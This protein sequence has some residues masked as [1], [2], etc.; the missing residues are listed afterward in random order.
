MSK[1]EKSISTVFFVL[2]LRDLFGGIELSFKKQSKEIQGIFKV[3]RVVLI[4]TWGVYPIAYLLPTI[5]GDLG[6]TA[7]DGMVLKQVG[8]T[9]A[10]ILAK[11]AFGLLVL[12]VATA[13]DATAIMSKMVALDFTP[14]V[15]ALAPFWLAAFAKS[16]D[17]TAP[18]AR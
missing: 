6:L 16:P 13:A 18:E 14:Q 4:A 15:I 12:A 1:S 11:P 17:W 8:Y 10:D 3:L 7:G 5:A 2:I 9:I